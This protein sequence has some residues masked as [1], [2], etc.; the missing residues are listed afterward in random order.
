[1]AASNTRAQLKRLLRPCRMPSSGI[2]RRLERTSASAVLLGYGLLLLVNLQVFSRNRD[3]RQLDTMAMAERLLV[4]SKGDQADGGALQRCFNHFSTFDRAIWGQPTGSAA[5]MVMPQLSSND[6]IASNPELRARAQDLARSASSPQTFAHEAR[7][8]TVSTAAVNLS[9]EPWRLYL[10]TDVSQDVAMERQLNLILTAAALLASLVTLMLNRRG[11]QRSLLPLRRFG[12]TLSAV[13]SS[14][15]QQK[16][17]EP[18]Q[19]P[20]ELQPLAHA[21][22]ALL[23]RLTEAFERQRQFASTVSHE[24]RN[25]ITLIG[26]YSRRLLRRSDNLSDDQRHQLGIVE[27]ESRRL[28]R[29]VTDLLALTRAE[30]GSLQLDLK[31]LSVCDAVQQAI[32]LAGGAGER[33]FL[34]RPDDGIDPHTLQAW[35]DRDRVV[36]CLVNL[37]ENACKYSPQQSPVEIGCSTTPS[38]V[39]LRVRDH[40][41]GIPP[42]ERSLIFE[43][44]RRGQ[45]NTGIPGSGIGLAVVSTLVSQM[46]GEVS[47]EDGEGGGAVFVISLR[48][49]PRPSDPRPRHHRH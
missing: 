37:I 48:R 38:V 41:P 30:T 11:I 40:G 34:L 10:L 28:G 46:E 4:R 49:C 27:E 6:F 14:S 2:Q 23:D 24:L 18:D 44:F 12:D 9:D 13:R 15:L 36:Q 1:M 8:Y 29:L 16:R 17:F 19:E 33:R 47:V 3:Q 39:E 21:F 5:G 32:D 42:E 25:P 22:N 31:P 35:A 43:R 26:G 7:T 45:H 20:E